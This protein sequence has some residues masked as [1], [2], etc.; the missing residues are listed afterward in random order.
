MDGH[1]ESVILREYEDLLTDAL[2]QLETARAEVASLEPIVQGLRRRVGRDPS[3]PSEDDH[4]PEPTPAELRAQG[5]SVYGGRP[6]L[7]GTLE[8]LMADG[9]V[10]SLD[11]IMG[12]LERNVHFADRTPSRNSLSN[13]L[14]DL[15][16]R[17][18]LVKIKV[19]KG[20]LYQLAP[21][22]REGADSGDTTSAAPAT[23]DDNALQPT[24]EV[25]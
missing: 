6:T 11:Q 13:R 5:R 10:R 23:T 1:R 24:G 14:A 8:E 16:D 12:E 7:I 2:T 9:T 25:T 21:Q 18:Y 4:E 15:V 22:H 19:G 3:K 20:R 17:D